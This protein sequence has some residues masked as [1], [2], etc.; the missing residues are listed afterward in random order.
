MEPPPHIDFAVAVIV[1]IVFHIIL[2][3]FL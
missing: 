2:G 3:V 1:V